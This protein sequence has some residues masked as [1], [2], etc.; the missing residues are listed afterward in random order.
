[1]I[2]AGGATISA[3]FYKEIISLLFQLL[4]KKKFE[5]EPN[6]NG[7]NAQ[8]WDYETISNIETPT[9]GYK[10]GQ[11]YKLKIFHKGGAMTLTLI[12]EEKPEYTI[13]GNRER[14]G[15]RVWNRWGSHRLHEG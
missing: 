7:C 2:L 13:Q 15:L 1:M 11:W 5:C 9:G 6:V 8:G 3:C 12:D 14:Y 10:T 4:V